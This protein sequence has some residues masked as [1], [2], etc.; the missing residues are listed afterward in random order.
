M[1]ETKNGDHF[2]RP[3]YPPK[4]WKNYIGN[5]FWPLESGVLAI[6]HI[7]NILGSFLEGKTGVFFKLVSSHEKLN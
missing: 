1:P 7:L 5:A 2:Y 6:L 3:N 4:P